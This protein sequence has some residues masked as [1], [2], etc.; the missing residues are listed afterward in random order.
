MTALIYDP[1]DMRESQRDILVRSGV[2]L[3]PEFEQAL[4]PTDTRPLEK[5][6]TGGV[7]AGKST[8]GAAETYID[9]PLIDFDAA[10]AD[11]WRY[12]YVMPTYETPKTELEYLIQ[13]T[14]A[15]YGMAESV[16]K[17]HMPA[18]AAAEIVLF[19]GRVIV[20]TRS[21]QDPEKIAAR[22]LRG[23]VLCEAGQ[24]SEGIRTAAL[25]RTVTLRGWNTYTGTLEDDEAKPRYAWYDQ[26][27]QRWRDDWS[28]GVA[29]SLPT[30]ANRAKFPLGQA[31]EYIQDRRSRLDEHTFNRRFAGIPSGVQYP[32]YGELLRGD[33]AYPDAAKATYIL[34]HGAGG[35]DYGT[36]PGHPSTLVV[37]QV[38]GDDIAI[39]RDAWEDFHGDAKRNELERQRLSHEYGVPLS[40][41]G[42][43]PMLKE[44]ADRSGATA[45]E[46]DNNRR[47]ARVGKVRARLIDGRLLFDLSNPMV[48]RVFEQMRR[49]HYQKRSSPTKGEYYE[50]HRS[51]DDLAAALEDAVTVIDDG[52][53]ILPQKTQVRKQM[54]LFAG[55]GSGWGYRG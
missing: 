37:V 2:E 8:L 54:P 28:E 35:Y 33:W 47:L 53:V 32:V 41:W 13:W 12:W 20:E 5:L 38:T 19:N 39:V 44:S 14:R 21:G 24:Q 10:L 45:M 51:D 23:C 9:F 3:S 40:R 16:I 22:A 50:Y 52:G 31:D 6:V 27:A 30:W 15:F 43:D 11:P 4:W 18:G 46:A 26:L 55:S 1:E 34:R 7:Q 36:T 29:V 42:F 49:V 25:E 17:V 48:V